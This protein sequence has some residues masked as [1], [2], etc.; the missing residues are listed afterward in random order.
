[1]NY[2]RRRLRGRRE[3]DEAEPVQASM[4]FAERGNLHLLFDTGWYLKRYPNVAAA[5]V[6]PFTHYIERGAAAGYDPHPMFWSAWYLERY[7]DVAAAGI[8]PLV[9][10]VI[11]GASEGRDPHPLFDTSWYLRRYPDVA[12]AGVNPLIHYVE[13][14]AAAGYDPHP[15]FC[16]AWY[17][18][19]YPE[20]AAAGVDPFTHYIERGA[21][22]RYDPHP[23]FWS[24]WYLDRY[25]D[26]AAAGINPLIH[27][28]THGGSEGRDPHPLFDTSW[29]LRHNPDAVTTGLNPLIHYVARGAPEGRQPGPLFSDSDDWELG[30][31]IAA[32]A[33]AQFDRHLRTPAWEQ[34]WVGKLATLPRTALVRIGKVCY[35]RSLFFIAW[36][37]YSIALSLFPIRRDE[38]LGLLAKCDVRRR[39]FDQAFARFLQLCDMVPAFNSNIRTA[40]M[41]IISQGNK[42]YRTVGVVTSVMPKRIEAQ[43]AALQ[44]WR[45]AGLSVVSVNSK[46]EA[47]EL[48]EYFPDITFRIIE[49]PVKDSL[50]RPLIPVKALVQTAQQASVDV[51]GIINSDIEFRGAPTFF[52][53]V[54]QEVPRSL[55]FGSRVDFPDSG[56][57]HGAAFRNGYDFFF[58]DKE[59]SLLFEETSMVLGLPWWDFWLPLHAHAQGL[60]IKR[61]AT[62][63]MV[64]VTHPIGYDIPAYVQFGHLCAETLAGAYG[65]WSNEYPPA[66]RVFLH[67]LFATAA[68]I[69]LHGHPDLALHR[70]A[71]VC[72][73]SNCLIDVISDIVALP[74]ARLASGT[75]DLL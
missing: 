7:P 67:R 35:A 43:Q 28:V 21:A 5:G 16:S 3:R 33:R 68:T 19:R 48:R 56:F 52:D 71:V 64:H 29:Y 46:S 72:D 54:R 53:L 22:A 61:F 6:D 75:L 60:R 26:V 50:G 44:S 58:W 45:A 62:S 13:R 74:D 70:I 20:V 69:P 31:D 42:I 10:Y 36:V 65:R 59:N 57:T 37:A 15:V 51:C 32:K 25:P 55:V 12:A 66:D 8:N 14:G 40:T 24:A 73:L 34:G 27:Y 38:L 41:P 47:A 2:L 23:M 9:H 1:M 30:R 39:R 18:K 17:L 4:V 63:S 11:H 49:N